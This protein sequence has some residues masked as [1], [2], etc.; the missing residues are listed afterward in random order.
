MQALRNVSDT[1]LDFPRPGR[2]FWVGC[3]VVIAAWTVV[4]AALL[5]I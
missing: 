3:A 1:P 5:Q 2:G 4:A